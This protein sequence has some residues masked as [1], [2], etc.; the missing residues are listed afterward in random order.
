M[1][2]RLAFMVGPL[3]GISGHSGWTA[4]L[5]VWVDYRDACDKV[6]E[7]WRWIGRPENRRM[8]GLPPFVARNDAIQ[9]Q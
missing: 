5:I 4:M 7:R 9:G 3:C 2:E 8:R 1:T 6:Q